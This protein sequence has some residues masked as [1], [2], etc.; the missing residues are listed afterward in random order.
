MAMIVIH[1]PQSEPDATQ[2]L[3]EIR[4]LIR[5]QVLEDIE[6]RPLSLAVAALQK[7]NARQYGQAQSLLDF[8]RE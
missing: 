5:S 6:I 3:R 4:K 1:A 2:R 7:R 8:V